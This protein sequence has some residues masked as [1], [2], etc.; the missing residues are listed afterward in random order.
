MPTEKQLDKALHHAFESNDFFRRWFASKLKAGPEFTALVSCR[1]NHPWSKVRLIVADPVTGALVPTDRE[2]ET[3]VLLV[4]EDPSGR[5]LG[6]HIEN[7]KDNGAFRELQPEMY[8]ARAEAWVESEN[9]GLYNLWETVLVAPSEFISRNL[10]EA[11]KFQTRITYDEI[12]Q[13][14]QLFETESTK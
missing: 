11:R 14:I 13:H 3:D 4:L 2:G 5:R 7:K 10:E 12:A 8:A 6:V 1:S 9:H